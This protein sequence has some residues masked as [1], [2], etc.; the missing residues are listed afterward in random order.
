M[1]EV[2]SDWVFMIVGWVEV[3]AEVKL[4]DERV[5]GRKK[6]REKKKKFKEFEE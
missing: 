5:W 2:A 4:W 3:K 6:R 1:P